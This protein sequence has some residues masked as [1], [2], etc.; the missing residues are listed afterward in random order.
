MS[1]EELEKNIA[2][3]IRAVAEHIIEN[4]ETYAKGID[5]HAQGMKIEMTFTIDA[6]PTVTVTQD[7]LPKKFIDA[8]GDG[9]CR[10]WTADGRRE[11]FEQNGNE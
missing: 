4:A 7:L 6:L 10:I 3:S 9:R 2:E 8:I 1:R 11:L 5:N